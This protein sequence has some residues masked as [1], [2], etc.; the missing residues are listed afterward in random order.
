MHERAKVAAKAETV[1][2]ELA[3]KSRSKS[4]EKRRS[5]NET[6]T[7]KT[8]LLSSKGKSRS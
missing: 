5:W 3:G 7:G 1:V 2:S 8:M 6:S 4:Y